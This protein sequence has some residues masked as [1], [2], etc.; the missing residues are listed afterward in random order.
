LWEVIDLKAPKD[1]GILSEYTK[2]GNA[3]ALGCILPYIKDI[4]TY[5]EDIQ[6]ALDIAAE[7]NDILCGC[8][9]IDY[10]ANVNYGMDG[11]GRDL[12]GYLL[13]PPIFRAV[14]NGAVE[15]LTLLLS[16]GGDPNVFNHENE[17]PLTAALRYADEEKRETMIKRL[18]ASG[19]DAE[20]AR[21]G[22][23]KRSSFLEYLQSEDLQY[24]KIPVFAQ[25][26]NDD[27]EVFGFYNVRGLR[28]K[29][30]TVIPPFFADDYELLSPLGNTL[31]FRKFHSKERIIVSFSYKPKFFELPEDDAEIQTGREIWHYDE[32]L[33][34]FAV[35][36]PGNGTNVAVV[37]KNGF[38][39]LY[40]S[41]EYRYSDGFDTISDPNDQSIRTYSL[42]GK[43][44]LLKPEGKSLAYPVF[45]EFFVYDP[46]CPPQSIMRGYIREEVEPK[47]KYNE[48]MFNLKI[49]SKGN[50]TVLQCKKLRPY[51]FSASF[52]LWL[53]HIS[54][55]LHTFFI[56]VLGL[57]IGKRAWYYF[58]RH[59]HLDI[60]K[61]MKESRERY[62]E[63]DLNT[64]KR[65]RRKKSQSDEDSASDESSESVLQEKIPDIF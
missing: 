60:K 1:I 11:K 25:A 38:Y 54:M 62:A 51:S 40:D 56:K 59:I 43:Y 46:N 39:Y 12:E 21:N 45:N 5:R 27:Y 31:I 57:I 58:Y 15:F 55:S 14:K 29:G 8:W 35:N 16:K 18:L 42:F 48:I 49:R 61:L 20:L 52:S 28:W 44:G 2:I 6:S 19:A 37:F 30:K 33:R 10:G 9:L 17:T 7:N 47:S 50:Q 23:S 13:N 22:N 32:T 53:H 41:T 4:A 64:P 26:L 34:H 65:K 63:I 3:D 36:R 24:K